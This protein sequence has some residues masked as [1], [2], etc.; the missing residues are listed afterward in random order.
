MPA[1]LIGAN[2]RTSGVAAVV[3]RLPD[4]IEIEFHDKERTS[5]EALGR[6]VAGERSPIRWT[7]RRNSM[8]HV[9]GRR[10]RS[11]FGQTASEKGAEQ[12]S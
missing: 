12:T 4:G 10:R 3:V 11:P 9:G 7:D 6:L 8:T 2:A 1:V 5:A